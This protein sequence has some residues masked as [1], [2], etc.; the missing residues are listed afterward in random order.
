MY[1]HERLFFTTHIVLPS[2]TLTNWTKTS[3]IRSLHRCGSV[4]SNSVSGIFT[5]AII[6]NMTGIFNWGNDMIIWYGRWWS[7]RIFYRHSTATCLPTDADG[8]GIGLAGTRRRRKWRKNLAHVYVWAEIADSNR[9]ED[10]CGASPRSLVQLH[11]NIM[12]RLP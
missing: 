11:C 2:L 12:M 8:L 10:F 9:W 6:C 3:R 5:S 1:A 4:N 7:Y